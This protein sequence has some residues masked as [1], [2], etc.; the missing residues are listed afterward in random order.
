M[1]GIGRHAGARQFGV[2]PRAARCAAS[3]GSSTSTAEPSPSTIPRR[4]RLKGRQVSGAITRIDSQAFR[5]PSVKQAS[6][7]PASARSA[8]PL[9]TMARACPMA[10]L[11]EEQALETVNA[12]PV[13]PCSMVRW[14]VAELAIDR[15]ITSG[16]TRASP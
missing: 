16:L 13:M 5:V 12:G 15:G 10:W 8:M 14:L 4:L 11:E 6:L 3:S 2:D 1:P 9:R 7:P